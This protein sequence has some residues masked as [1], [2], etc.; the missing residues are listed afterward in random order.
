MNFFLGEKQIMTKLKSLENVGRKAWLATIGTYA[1]GWELL[2]SKVN[3][4]Y[5]E[6]NQFIN[7]CVEN[8]E[9]IESNLKEKLKS[10]NVL[11]AKIAALKIKLGVDLSY[12]NKLAALNE[13][14]NVLTIEVEKL[15]TLRS[16]KD[17]ETKAIETKAVEVKAVSKAV[18]VDKVLPPKKQEIKAD[19]IVV[20][21]T[22]TPASKKS[23]S[24]PAIKKAKTA[25]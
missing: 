1:K 8:G 12:E 15:I 9:K 23:A 20:N 19:S 6:T 4:K 21:K 10:N 17:A 2:S 24:S 22:K 13:K 5:V 7:E 25:N 18:V 11:D 16:A 14:V 3:D